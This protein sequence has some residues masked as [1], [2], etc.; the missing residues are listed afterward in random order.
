MRFSLLFL[1]F[2]LLSWASVFAQDTFRRDAAGAYLQG[3][4]KVKPMPP[5]R[6]MTERE[7]ATIDVLNSVRRYPKAAA[8]LLRKRSDN[9]EFTS[10]EAS[11]YQTLMTLAPDTTYFIF[12][13]TLFD[14]NMSL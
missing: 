7:L 5:N 2:I 1:G 3:L 12:D 6:Y 9:N 4:P 11:L 14:G 10:N 13:T 8:A